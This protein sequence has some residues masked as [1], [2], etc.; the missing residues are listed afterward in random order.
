MKRHL[1][2]KERKIRDSLERYENVREQHRKSRI[3]K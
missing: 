1:K 2:E 3:N